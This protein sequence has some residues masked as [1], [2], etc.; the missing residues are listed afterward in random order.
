MSRYLR[1]ESGAFLCP[2]CGVIKQSQSN[3]HY[4]LKKHA[5]D[6]GYPC[7]TCGNRFL[8]KCALDMHRK[9]RHAAEVAAEQKEAEKAFRC[10]VAGC[11]FQSPSKGNVQIHYYRIHCKEQL[12]PYRVPVP[13]TAHIRCKVCNITFKSDVA[14]YYHGAVHCLPKD[15]TRIHPST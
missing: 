14:F 10:S 3:M 6:P 13:G 8:Q 11:T 15:L 7:R 1:T 9:T 12:A 2:V 5:D 4:H